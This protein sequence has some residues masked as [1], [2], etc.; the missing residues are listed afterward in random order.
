MPELRS[1]ARYVARDVR[2]RARFP[3]A[4]EANLLVL[5]DFNIDRRQGDP[6]F[7]AFVE[8]GLWVPEPLRETRTTYGREAKHY[9]QIAWFRDDFDLLTAGRAGAVD[10]AGTVYPELTPL[11][12]SFRVSDHFPLWIEFLSDRSAEAMARTLG[13]DS[14]MPDPF[15]DVPD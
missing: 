13:V 4:E 8:T 3:G 10:F 12:K 7:D 2:D 15:R 9:D 11:Q 6:L 14:A 5:G 1:L